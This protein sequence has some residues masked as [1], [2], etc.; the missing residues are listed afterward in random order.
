MI[1]L[2]HKRRASNLQWVAEVEAK[3]TLWAIPG[4][5]LRRSMLVALA[6]RASDHYAPDVFLDG[7]FEE[8]KDS[9]TKNFAEEE[10]LSYVMETILDEKLDSVLEDNTTEDIEESEEDGECDTEYDVEE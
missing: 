10:I 7:T 5:Y 1:Y 9:P 2:L 8:S 3:G 6:C 4:P